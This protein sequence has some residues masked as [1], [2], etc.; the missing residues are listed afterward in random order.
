MRPGQRPELGRQGEGRQE[1]LGR[2]LLVHLALD[3]LRALV[4]LTVRAVAM[5]AGMGNQ[6]VVRALRARQ[7]ALRAGVRAAL[8]DR[9]QRLQVIGCQPL[10][11]LRQEI[12][13]EALDDWCEPDHFTVSQAMENPSIRALMGSSAWC[14]VWSVRWV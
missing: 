1:V 4:G 10:A 11:V 9:G 13:L 7:L 6:A 12:R 3:P 8:P 5:A 2:H 14:L